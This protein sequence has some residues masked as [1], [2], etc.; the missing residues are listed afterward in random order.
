METRTHKADAPEYIHH[1]SKTQMSVSR[2]FG[3]CTYNGASYTYIAADDCLIRNDVLKRDERA[4]QQHAKSERE[5]WQKA[6]QTLFTNPA[7][8]PD[9]QRPGRNTYSAKSSNHGA[10]KSSPNPAPPPF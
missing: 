1:V 6:Q 8:P 2:H 5:R 7:N 10:R 9:Q 4:R 3:G